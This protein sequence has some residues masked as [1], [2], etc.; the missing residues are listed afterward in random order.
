VQE[1]TGLEPA[2]PSFLGQL[3]DLGLPY[4]GGEQGRFLAKGIASI[5]LTTQEDGDPLVPVGDQGGAVSTER[6]GQM[7]RA[8]ETLVGSLD[9]NAGSSLRTPDS[10][11]FRNRSA[12]GW[13]ARL[14]LVVA[15]VP[16]A[17]G[18]LDLL[19]RSRRR[20]LPL[21]SALRALRSRLFFWL[22]AGILLWLGTM[23]NVFPSSPDLPPPPYAR[24]VVD[25]PLAG[26]L[27]LGA[28]LVVGWLFARRR[29]LPSE[30]G[31][32]A[33]DRLA[34]YA[35]AFVWI[36]LVAFVIAVTTPYA[37]LFVLPSLYAWLW[38]P[39]QSR[40]WPRVALFL[41]GL[42]GPFLGLL[43]LASQLGL[44][45]PRTAFY[46]LGL[47][48]SGYLPLRSL[49]LALAWVVGAAQVAALAFGRYAPYAG[50]IGPVRQAL[51]RRLAR[52]RSY[53][54]AR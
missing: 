32:T 49:V 12:S 14:T 36:G 16:F 30:A 15:V 20:R 24:S 21:G 39:L 48:T 34:G 8:T 47:M 44:S 10:L 51:A 26:L 4:A 23:A 38:L 3:V 37:L 5:T 9:A 28:A 53:A 6:L 11:F 19:V 25:L 42:A 46:V 40:L 33:E 1:Q 22:Y 7:G 45:L 29:L 18:A 43:L 27:L 35:I 41:A 17:L 31:V 13:A 54:S 52:R 2:I 50:G